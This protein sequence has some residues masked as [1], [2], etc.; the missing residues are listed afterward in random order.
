MLNEQE[1]AIFDNAASNSL[2]DGLSVHG[3]PK[4][5]LEALEEMK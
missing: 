3:N 5:D 4:R 2:M 1:I